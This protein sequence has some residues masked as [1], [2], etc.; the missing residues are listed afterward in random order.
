L[1]PVT[2]DG[3]VAIFDMHGLVSTPVTSFTHNSSS[4]ED[5]MTFNAFTKNNN[6]D[7][8]DVTKDGLYIS[9]GIHPIVLSEVVGSDLPCL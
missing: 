4:I 9:S 1:N 6:A 5:L 3:I 8:D 2:A 7:D